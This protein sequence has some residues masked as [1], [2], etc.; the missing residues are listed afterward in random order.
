MRLVKTFCNGEIK[1]QR[2]FTF[3]IYI[4]CFFTLFHKRVKIFGALSKLLFIG[5]MSKLLFMGLTSNRFP[6][7]TW[8]L[9]FLMGLRS[10]LPCSLFL[11]G[12]R[13]KLPLSLFL[14]GLTSKFPWCLF[15]IGLR[16]KLPWSLAL[17][18]IG[19]RSK[20]VP[21]SCKKREFML[22]LTTSK[23]VREQVCY[24]DAF[25][26]QVLTITSMAPLRSVTMNERHVNPT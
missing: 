14:M 23:Q 15:R 18:R 5:L 8:S 22:K 11:I 19:L 3:S 20:E 21:I 9:F 10:K 17:F 4:R 25:I 24:T 6:F 2:D 13:S 12:L 16:S 26:L 7:S 1:Y